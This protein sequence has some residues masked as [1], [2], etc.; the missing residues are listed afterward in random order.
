MKYLT[1]LVIGD[2]TISLC[3]A[4]HVDHSIAHTY[5]VCPGET[6]IITIK[7]PT[8]ITMYEEDGDLHIAPLEGG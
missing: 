8:D 1:L 6:D 5:Q 7:S 3:E 2:V 4:V